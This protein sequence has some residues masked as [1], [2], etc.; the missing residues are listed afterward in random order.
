MVVPVRG[1]VV[2]ES[3]P[4]EQQDARQS[5]V[6][7]GQHQHPPAAQPTRQALLKPREEAR[8]AH[9]RNR[10]QGVDADVEDEPQV[11]HRHAAEDLRHT[12]LVQPPRPEALAPA[13]LVDRLEPGLRRH[14]E[15]DPEQQRRRQPRHPRPRHRARGILARHEA[16]RR[17]GHQEQ[18][19]Q[20]P[21]PRGQDRLG[22]PAKG[23][24]AV[25]VPVV[26]RVHQADVEHDQQA[27]RCDPDPVQVV[28]AARAGRSGGR[29]GF[30]E[31]SVGGHRG[32]SCQRIAAMATAITSL[33]LTAPV[34][35]LA[36]GAR[37][38]TF[39]SGVAQRC[40]AAASNLCNC[41]GVPKIERFRTIQRVTDRRN[42]PSS[43]R[44][45]PT[46]GGRE[47]RL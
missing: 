15:E 35:R 43:S 7:D 8:P 40:G 17:A 10:G 1:Q 32:G 25:H 28:T 20:P 4:R 45:L 18:Q 36:F 3:E 26:G 22:E 2:A 34:L 5:Q 13:A 46:V 12:E 16:Q 24:G 37:D 6:E 31:G 41:E 30:R 44:P 14:E 21:W 42:R 38:A 39:G 19:R 29:G 33:R 27:E 23:V 9:Q 11:V 47:R